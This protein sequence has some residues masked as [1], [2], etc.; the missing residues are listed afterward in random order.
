M[1]L[2]LHYEEKL[3]FQRSLRFITRT[4]E[5]HTLHSVVYAYNIP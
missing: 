2:E 3:I 4:I 5:G 1:I